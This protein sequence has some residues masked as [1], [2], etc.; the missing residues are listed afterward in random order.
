MQSALKTSFQKRGFKDAI[1]R[2]LIV[3]CTIAAVTIC[4]AAKDFVKPEAKP[5]QSYPAHDDH[6][7]E[8]VAIAADPYDTAEKARIF[9][10]KFHDH[11]FLPIFFIV[12]NNGNQPISIANLQVTLTTADRDKLTPTAPE[13]IYRR[14]TNPHPNTNPIPLP[15]PQKKVKGTISEKEKT[16]VESSQF[17]AKAVEPH[18]TQS[19][20]F[21]FD[22]EGIAAPLAGAHLY[23]SGVNDAKGSELMY[24]EIPL[25]KYLNPQQ[26]AN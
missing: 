5:A 3:L 18:N 8:K 23:I 22:V 13:D 16:E 9:S 21:F 15:I 14:I 25:D 19:G 17:V 20:F 2:F 26:K 1:S 6:A 12:T 24:F 4:V 7:D 11:G 10:V